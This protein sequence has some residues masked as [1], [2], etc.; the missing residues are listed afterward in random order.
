MV[1]SNFPTSLLS[2][3]LGCADLSASPNPNAADAV[4][5]AQAGD[6]D[7][8]SEL[9]TEHKWRVFSV[10]MRIVRDSSLAEDLTQETF[11]QVFRKIAAFRGDA[12]FTTWLHRVAVNTVLMHLRKRVLSV[13]SLDHLMSNVEDEHLGRSFGARDLAQAGAIDRLAIERAVAE[14]AP[15]Y[16]S[17]FLLHDVDGFDYSEIASMLKCSRG[18]TKSQLHKARRVLRRALT[19]DHERG[20]KRP[21]AQQKVQGLH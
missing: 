20:S 18:N 14:L 17:I 13:V 11:L 16:R 3:A 5:R 9:Y 8:F 15:G 12:N 21:L 6:S 2:T 10:C 7:A 1:T 4:A 19:V